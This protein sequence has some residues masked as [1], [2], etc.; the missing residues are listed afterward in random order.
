MRIVEKRSPKGFL[1]LS[2]FCGLSF[3][4]GAFRNRLEPG[5]RLPCI[6]QPGYLGCRIS[7]FGVIIQG[8]S[9]RGR[10][11]Y[12]SGREHSDPTFRL[13]V[14]L[15]RGVNNEVVVTMDIPHYSVILKAIIGHL[16]HTSEGAWG[17]MQM[18]QNSCPR[19]REK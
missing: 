13:F 8:R 12:Y 16:P 6:L 10:G 19:Q 11:R 4:E 9:T 15:G 14:S 18:L 1:L 3:S 5:R 17:I 7:F 2:F